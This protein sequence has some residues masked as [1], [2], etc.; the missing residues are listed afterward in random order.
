MRDD[1]LAAIA[2]AL[3]A[4]TPAAETEEIT[5]C[6]SRWKFAARNADMEIEDY[7]RV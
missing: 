7:R 3:S 4:V 6:R 1:E 5:E 2:A